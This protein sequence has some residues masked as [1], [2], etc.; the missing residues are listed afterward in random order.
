MVTLTLQATLLL[1]RRCRLIVCFDIGGPK[2]SWLSWEPC[3][4]LSKN[5]VG[6]YWS[7]VEIYGERRGSHRFSLG[8]W[9]PKASFYSVVF[10][11][12]FRM[13]GT[14]FYSTSPW[15]FFFRWACFWWSSWLKHNGIVPA[16]S[17]RAFYENFAPG[18]GT[19]GLLCHWDVASFFGQLLGGSRKI[20]CRHLSHR[21]GL[22]L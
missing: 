12:S 2:G 11:G 16:A 3:W 20:L 8:W 18:Y 4:Q 22:V 5:S 13:V 10:R 1:I 17:S 9:C 7:Y 19:R 15:L 6:L 21:V 14:G